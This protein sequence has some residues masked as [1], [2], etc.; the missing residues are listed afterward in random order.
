MLALLTQ[1]GTEL[2]TLD[3]A[4]SRRAQAGIAELRTLVE[5]LPTASAADAL[6]PTASDFLRATTLVLMAWA[7]ARLDSAQAPGNGARAFARWVWPELA[8]RC[9][10]VRD[11]MTV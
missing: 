4:A 2:D 1:L 9:G 3:S 7:W 5:A 6:Y 10:M 8:M 11:A